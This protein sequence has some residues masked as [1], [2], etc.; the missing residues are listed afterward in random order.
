[1]LHQYWVLALRQ[2][3]K[4]KIQSLVKILGL[5]L[6]LAG[7]LLVVVVNYSESTWD[8]FWDEADTIYKF[9]FYDNGKAASGF[10]P[11]I[12]AGALREQA[13]E[14]AAVGNLERSIILV[15]FPDQQSKSLKTF[16]QSVTRIDDGILD[17]FTFTP[18]EGAIT[19]FRNNPS[20][21][22][23][24]E[25]AAKKYFGAQSALGKTFAIGRSQLEGPA[26]DALEAR[27]EQRLYTVVAVIADVNQ[28]SNEV[29]QVMVPAL[30]AV[31][32]SDRNWLSRSVSTYIKLNTSNSLANI[33]QRL[34][35]YVK[36]QLEALKL[37]GN[38]EPSFKA[39]PI[40]NVHTQGAEVSG[41]AQQLLLLYVLGFL[42][43]VITLVN[44]INLSISGYLQRS[45]E[46]G[47]RRLVGASIGQLFVQI[48]LESILYLV[49]AGLF[50][51]MVLEPLLPIIASS[52]SI[53]LGNNL[54][55]EPSLMLIIAGLFLCAS[56]LVAIYPVWRVAG[57]SL[58]FSLR[59]NRAR[60]NLIDTRVRKMF[61]LVQLIAS[62]LLLI[63]VVVVNAQLEKFS[64]F[65][66]GY[67][68]KSIYFF[69][70]QEF[71]TANKGQFLQLKARLEQNPAIESMAR[72]GI[73][74]LGA[75][76]EPG[77]VSTLEQD[78]A[79]GVAIAFQHVPDFN[80]LRVFD[81]PIVAGE[82]PLTGDKFLQSN[83]TTQPAMSPGAPE[84][85]ELVICENLLPLLG[86]PNAQSAINQTIKFYMGDFG[87]PTKIIAV[88]GNFHFGEFYSAPQPC[89]FWQVT[90][91]NAMS[92][93]IQYKNG[94][95]TE[96]DAY[97]KQVWKEVMGGT[98]YVIPLSGM[99][100]ASV[101]REKILRYFLQVIAGIALVISLLGVFG[102]IQLTLQKRQLEIALRKLHGASVRQILGMLN[103]EFAILVL[104]ANLLALPVGFYFANQWLEN[105]YQPIELLWWMPVALA[106]SIGLSLLLTQSTVT[107]QSMWVAR[108]RP[109]SSLTQH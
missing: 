65:D 62:S 73:G 53:R 105:F 106:I 88:T 100:E 78:R 4:H 2:L 83:P 67:T 1:M 31:T 59:A 51:F 79:H 20:A 14:L 13:P 8:N 89:A 47:V 58:A 68:T 41:G 26:P 7:A 46:V 93:G 90:F 29:F 86:F 56:V 71:L 107:L 45:K 96:V 35:N 22:I 54:L 61:Y 23:L 34:N 37:S 69:H 19:G 80:G 55:L 102:L 44:H 95:F 104:V 60:E 94:E 103:K 87:I 30:E 97:L 66:P 50:A 38:A 36:K 74:L 15:Q 52:L 5:T 42:V 32:E 84:F 40:R 27:E 3:W 91:G 77:W 21:A 101:G 57:L 33:E 10:T 9:E 24:S 109:A 25:T 16:S 108:K 76:A 75:N 99:V 64:R 39:M 49:L 92:W 98:P 63:S 11:K 72:M 43:L 18:L 12:L 85:K 82:L 17:I 48:W 28:R 81:V 70:G 6:G